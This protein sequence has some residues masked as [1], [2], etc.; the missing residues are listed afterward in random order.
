MIIGVGCDIVEHEATRSLGWSINLNA[1][2]RVFSC[3]ELAL[4]SGTHSDL[5]LS[6]RFAGKEAILKCLGTGLIDG[7]AL[8]DLE[9]LQNKQGKPFIHIGGEAARIAEKLGIVKWHISIS[10]A[11][12]FST[13]FVLAEG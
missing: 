12:G 11:T 4:S 7:V 13:A 5:F 8:K 3:R 9:I 6:G 1:R 2:K 10:H